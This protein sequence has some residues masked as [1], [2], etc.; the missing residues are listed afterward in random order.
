YFGPLTVHPDFWD[1]GVGQKLVE[2]AIGL[3]EAWGC[4][5]TGLYTYSGS[6]KHLALYQK[7]GFWPRALTAILS[8]LVRPVE[9]VGEVSLYSQAPASARPGLVA[10]AA[11]LTDAIYAGLDV[12]REILALEAQGLG[13]TVFIWDDPGL[14]GFAAM[15]VGPG[16]E[17]GSGAG[18]IKFGAARPGPKAGEYFDR[19]LTA[20]EA[21][22]AS[23]G[24]QRLI[25]GVSL[26]RQPAYEQMRAR[27][28]Q[29]EVV[30]VCMH[31]P[32]EP[33]YHRPEVFVIDDWLS[34]ES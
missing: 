26:A 33:G 31:K 7:F 20:C 27:G 16:S 15:H 23:Q 13:D 1:R 30:G 29:P 4:R 2:P 21:Y 5:H 32:N 8:K 12:Q 19:L 11:G 34:R 25:V 28:F 14:V 3:F 10:A 9:R 6:P 22:A 24:A 17:A 18:F